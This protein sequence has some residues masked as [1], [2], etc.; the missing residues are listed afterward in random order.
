MAYK[1]FRKEIGKDSVELLNDKVYETKEEAEEAMH[2]AENKLKHEREHIPL[3]KEV[4]GPGQTNVPGAEIIPDKEKE[5]HG[6]TE[7]FIR[8]V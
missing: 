6:Q 7:F 2:K 4:F 8:E 5:P 3:P 1:V